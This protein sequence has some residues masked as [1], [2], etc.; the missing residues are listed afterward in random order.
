MSAARQALLGL[1]GCGGQGQCP[2]LL[3][4]PSEALFPRGG[5]DQLRSALSLGLPVPRLT[6]RSTL[7][8]V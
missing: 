3:W 5:A 7:G 2:P 4:H 8:G 6:Q 1:E